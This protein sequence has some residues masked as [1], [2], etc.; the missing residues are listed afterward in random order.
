[1]R[2]DQ[3]FDLFWEKVVMKAEQRSVETPLLP[4]RRKLPSRFE[5]EQA[6]AEFHSTPMDYYRQNY[7]EAMNH[8]VQAITD[9]FDQE[10]FVVYLDTEQLLLKH[11]NLFP[12]QIKTLI[13]SH[14]LK[15]R[16]R[17][18]CNRFALSC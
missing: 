15:N 13:T 8:I 1:M 17:F 16:D 5:T 11:D 4:R 7:F 6:P 2:C 12:K 14:P 9:R 3:C 18:M 10:D